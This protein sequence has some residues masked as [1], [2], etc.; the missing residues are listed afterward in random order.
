MLVASIW[1]VLAMLVVAGVFG[2]YV[3]IQVE[4]ARKAKVRTA[5][6]L[7]WI[8]TEQTLLYLFAVNGMTR[9]GLTVGGEKPATIRLDGTRYLGFGDTTFSVDDYG[10]LVGVN[11][12]NNLHLRQ[13]LDSYSM[14]D[15]ARN[16]L[17]DNLY[18]YIDLDTLVRLNG[19]EAIG[20]KNSDFSPANEFIKSVP[21][22]RNVLGWEAFLDSHPGFAAEDW[23]STNWRSR[24]NLN[25]VPVSL[26]QRVL[27][28]TIEEAGRLVEA[29]RQK[30]FRNMD[31]VNELLNHRVRLIE[32]YYT[33]LPTGDVRFRIH[34]GNSSKVS[35][36]VVLYSPMSVR[37]PWVVD[38]RY[39]S[40]RRTNRK[41]SPWVVAGK[42]FGRKPNPAG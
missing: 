16:E 33:F 8:A 12:Y 26:M 11:V 38:Y 9:R 6:S 39:Q 1:L 31:S 3:A 24:I 4:Q 23:L 15:S 13:V 17:L 35:T 40:E 37:T 2:V 20:A 42:F 7:D 21:E 36:M 32:D 14:A 22:L 10:G 19:Y 18:D 25:T 28:I 41:T 27:P 29:R 5:E 34:S 30:P